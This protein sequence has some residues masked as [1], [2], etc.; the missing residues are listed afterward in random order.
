PAPPMVPVAPAAAP[1]GMPREEA[2]DGKGGFA[3]RPLQ[4][5]GAGEGK[6]MRLG[7]QNRRLAVPADGAALRQGHAAGLEKGAKKAKED[8]AADKPGVALGGRGAGM[9]VPLAGVPPAAPQ[10]DFALPFGLDGQ[11]RE[12]KRIAWPAMPVR[13]YRHPRAD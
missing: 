6:D 2:K 13:E 1:P 10:A 12:R 11:A 7:E 5:G 8:R 3:G 4:R 9:P